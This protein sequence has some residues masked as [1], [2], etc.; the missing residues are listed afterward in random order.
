MSQWA[1]PDDGNGAPAGTPGGWGPTPPTEP[2]PAQTPSA[3]GGPAA[4]GWGE[5]SWNERTGGWDRPAAGQPGI[6]PLRPIG[7][8]EIWD[9]AFRAFRQ[10]PKV[11]VGLSAIVVVAT[12][13]VSLVATVV[14]TRDLVGLAEQLGAGAAADVSFSEVAGTLQRSI[15]LYLVVT[16]LQAVA[17]LVLNGML[18]VAVSRAVLGRTVTL[19]ELWR[20]TRRRLPALLGLSLLLSLVPALVGLVALAPGILVLVGADGDAAIASGVVLTLAGALVWAVVAVFLWIRWALATP[21]LLLERLTVRQAVRRS[22][23]LVKGSFWRTLGILLL[24]LVVV[25]AV[26]AAVGVPFS[27][28]GQAVVVATGSADDP[29]GAVVLQQVIASVGS[30]IG[31][32]VA[33]PF[34]ASVTALVYVDLRMRREGLDVEL[35]RA[36]AGG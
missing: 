14:L 11:M 22:S 9:G 34:L 33:Y 31:S 36:A 24:T 21:A 25:Y 8:G 32:V 13:L 35:H 12:Q 19:G 30:M 2:A 5:P 29:T 20:E 7:L 6:I 27:L 23:R 3:G 15:P 16:L 26:V 4:G 18:I 1:A 17:V 10:N 28:V